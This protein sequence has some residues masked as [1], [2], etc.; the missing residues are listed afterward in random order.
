VVK[1]SNALGRNF[2]DWWL[3]QLGR[4]WP[5][6]S[7]Q[8]QPN[9]DCYVKLADNG[10]RLRVARTAE[11]QSTSLP[12]D[13]TASEISALLQTGQLRDSPSF[14]IQ[15]EPS[16]FL[17]RDLAPKRLPPRQG[18][19]MAELDLLASTPID[20]KQAHIVFTDDPKGGCVYHVVKTKTLAPTLGAIR[21]AGGTVRSIAIAEGDQERSIDRLSLISIWP[22]TRREKFV[23]R[24]WV[25]ACAIIFLS[26]AATYGLLP[27]FRTRN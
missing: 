4:L 24:A 1:I 2:F 18:R 25:T 3:D 6:S 17:T 9:V 23:L 10:V 11:F 26:L 22:P 12:V 8:R 21:A 19:T 5:T 7:R 16:L 20:P 13:A 27:V 14:D 15:I